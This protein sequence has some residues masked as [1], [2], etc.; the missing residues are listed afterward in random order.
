MANA[1][2]CA[3]C[4][5]TFNLIRLGIELLT[6]APLTTIWNSLVLP[7]NRTYPRLDFVYDRQAVGSV[8]VP[9]LCKQFATLD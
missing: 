8:R 4:G 2:A 5:M 7:R 3:V 9:Q 1:C 6:A